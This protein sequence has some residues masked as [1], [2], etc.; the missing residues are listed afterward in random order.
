VPLCGARPYRRA[1]AA[2][3]SRA[4]S[5]SLESDHAVLPVRDRSWAPGAGSSNRRPCT[6][7]C[8]RQGSEDA[9][10]GVGACHPSRCHYQARIQ[11]DG[12]VV[13]RRCGGYIRRQAF[14]HTRALSV[15]NDVQIVRTCAHSNYLVLLVNKSIVLFVDTTFVRHVVSS[16]RCQSDS[17]EAKSW[18]PFLRFFSTDADTPFLPHA[19]NHGH[20]RTT[21]CARCLPMLAPW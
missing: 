6:S 7:A 15:L 17:T 14:N 2:S 10:T 13:C 21:S 19:H 3:P 12:E 1:G 5:P 20:R 11:V 9:A 8:W 4:A 16:H 18:V